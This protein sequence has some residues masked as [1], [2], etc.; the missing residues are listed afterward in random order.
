MQSMQFDYIFI[1][2]DNSLKILLIYAIVR[3]QRPWN[4]PMTGI[5]EEPGN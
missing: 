2:T 4:S 1:L 5:I 3:F